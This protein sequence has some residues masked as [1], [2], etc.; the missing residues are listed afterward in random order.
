MV[1]KLDGGTVI[2]Q[3]GN[4]NIEN[5]RATATNPNATSGT[6][7]GFNTTFGYT[8]GGRVTVPGSAVNQIDRFELV[9][10]ANAA[11]VGDLIAAK[12]YTAGVASTTHGYS[13]GGGYTPPFY[14]YNVIE[15]FPFSG[16]TNTSDVGDLTDN[17]HGIAG[18]QSATHGYAQQGAKNPPSP[19][20]NTNVIEKFPFSSDANGS[21]VGDVTVTRR[22]AIG[23]SSLTHGYASG[24]FV[25][26][27]EVT[28]NVIDNTPFA[29]DA[30]SSDV[31]DLTQSRWMGGG[32]GSSSPSHGYFA[33]GSTNGGPT[34]VN[35]IDKFPF[36]TDA[37]ASDVGELTYTSYGSCGITS[38]THGYVAGRG[39]PPISNN[40]ERYPF[41]SDGGGV[42]VGDLSGNR[43][44]LGGTQ[45]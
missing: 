6:S 27:G 40:I 13:V 31:G 25:S 41:I 21:D 23:Q 3:D 33:G 20:T 43:Y 36:S 19:T 14:D 28:T 22:Y 8:L 2:D 29:S 32:T 16:L 42:D 12:Y 44:A 9:S 10:R 35:T 38:E 26:P 4:L 17:R 39:Y 15:K 24:G 30:N 11:D 7:I 37:N 34:K 18:A 45:G 5:L 1:Y